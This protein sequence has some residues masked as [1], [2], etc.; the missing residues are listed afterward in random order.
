MLA[1]IA[2]IVS[3]QADER[4]VIISRRFYRA[5]EKPKGPDT[6]PDYHGPEFTRG[7]RASYLLCQFML[8]P[9]V[10]VFHASMAASIVSS[11]SRS[12]FTVINSIIH[13]PQ[14]LGTTEAYL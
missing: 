3:A 9:L 13:S 11:L 1:D 8:L 2:H 10:A 6:L 4:Q 12:Y 7:P 5:Q 14:Q